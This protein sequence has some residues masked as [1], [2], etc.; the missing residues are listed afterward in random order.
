MQNVKVS[1]KGNLLVIEIDATQDLG[2][3]KSGKTRMVAS[4]NGNQKI[5]VAGRELVIGLNAYTAK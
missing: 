3:S 1:T 4:T 2:F 5:A